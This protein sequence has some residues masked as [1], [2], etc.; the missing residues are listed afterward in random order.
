[1]LDSNGKV[2]GAYYEEA[3]TNVDLIMSNNK[4]DEIPKDS[5]QKRS[6]HDERMYRVYFLGNELTF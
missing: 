5:R 4:K 3:L 6:K 1:M 2:V